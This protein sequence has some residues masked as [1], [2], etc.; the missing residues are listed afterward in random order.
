[1]LEYALHRVEAAWAAHEG[2]AL[3][4]SLDI[5]G[6]EDPLN[7]VP[8]A[9][10]GLLLERQGRRAEAADAL[11]AAA[12]LAPDSP[13]PMYL[14]GEVL[15]RCNRLSE[16]E[17]TLRLASELDPT[18]ERLRNT[19]AAVLF[20]M[21]RHTARSE[22]LRSIEQHGENVTELCNLANA[23]TCL[24]LQK[25]GVTSARRA[26]ELAP[27]A[28]APWRTLCNTLP[29]QDGITGQ[30]LLELR[31]CSDR[32]PRE[33]PPEFANCPD[34]ER[35]LVVGLLSGSLRVHPVGWLTVA[36]F[37]VLDPAMF[38]LVCLA[39]N[40][41]TDSIARRYRT[42][43]REWHD[44]DAMSDATLAEAARAL[45]ID[46]LIDLGGYGDLGRMPACAYRLA[47]V[48]VKWVGMQTHSSGLAEMD[49]IITDR[50]ETPAELEHVYSERPLRMPDGYVC[51]SPP[52]YAPDVGPLPAM[53]NEHITFGCFNNLAKITPLVIATW[54]DVLHWAH[55][56]R[57]VLKAHQ[58][59]DPDT[60]HRVLTAF[61]ER[62]IAPERIELRGPSGHRA[63]SAGIQRHRY[64]AG[65]VSLLWRA[66]NLRSAMDGR[67]DCDGAGRDL[68]VTTLHESSEQRGPRRLD[69]IEYY[70][71]RR[72][73]RRESNRH[74]NA[75]R[76][77]VAAARPG[78]SEPAM[79]RVAL[80][81][82]P[83]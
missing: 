42:L 18:N 8:L 67:T 64:R 65:S 56:S 17:A 44:V 34:P 10:R 35:P 80:W 11:E 62:D 78:E 46:I 83:R 60:A 38:S 75:G 51:Y 9:A 54:C 55:G 58:F 5:A 79:R 3:L 71:L 22:L 43:A 14:L 2:E 70:S 15:A 73:R 24:G 57:L 76:T 20:R 4:A 29:Y 32:L 25:E 63:F 37:E 41:A 68:R 45:G 28:T 50:W 36:G 26:I 21:H 52:P 47:P 66:D 69:R 74:R 59:S 27:E 6:K 33:S 19:R 82:Q 23:T 16:A 53:I 81:P 77:P 12:A 13:L 72:A 31:A 30:E 49:W 40:S 7:P 48:Q 61:C 1:M 39:Q